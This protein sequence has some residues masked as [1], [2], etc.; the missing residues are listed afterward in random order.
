MVSRAEPT[1]SNTH[2]KCSRYRGA[3]VIE[4][5]LVALVLYFLTAAILD[6]GRSMLIAQTAQGAVNQFARELALLEL[7]TTDDFG[8]A[9]AAAEDRG[10]YDERFLVIDLD[11]VA[12]GGQTLDEYFGTLPMI[13]RSLRSLMIL[14]LVEI[15][16]AQSRFLRVPGALWRR[17]DGAL[18]VK[19]PLVL[20]RDAD[21][22]ETIAI[23]DVVEEIERAPSVGCYAIDP[24]DPSRSGLAAVRLRIPFQ[25][26]AMSSFRPAAAGPYEPNLS[27]INVADDG[28]VTVASSVAGEPVAGNA[29]LRTFS[30]PYGLG[31]Q[32]ALNKDVRPFRR[33]VTVQAVFRREVFAPSAP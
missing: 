29:L 22:V 7:D 10:I 6:L 11:A 8:A 2:S 24:A 15:D 28:T 13:N 16:G 26:A 20:S 30:G 32:E 33:V 4:F 17:P 27:N 31:S 23:R 14:D 12:A 25:A 9:L 3:A 5:A 18:T 1:R 21:G 19:V